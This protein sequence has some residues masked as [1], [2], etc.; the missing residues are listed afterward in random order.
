M[1]NFLI[2]HF[3]TDI[4]LYFIQSTNF[5]RPWQTPQGLINTTLKLSAICMEKIIIIFLPTN[6]T[7]IKPYM[8]DR[9]KA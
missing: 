5:F 7:E 3:L 4:L 9:I 8:M 6:G 2:G 1:D